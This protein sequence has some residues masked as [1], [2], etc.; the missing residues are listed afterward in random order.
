V[1]KSI[2]FFFSE[3]TPSDFTVKVSNIPK[4]L[5]VDKNFSYE[6]ELK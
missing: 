5:G 6:D 3:I 2:F 4:K 1:I